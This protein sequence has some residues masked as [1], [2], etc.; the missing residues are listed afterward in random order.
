MALTTRLQTVPY[1]WTN[2]PQIDIPGVVR[3]G[4]VIVRDSTVDVDA[5]PSALATQKISVE[6]TPGILP[7]TIPGWFNAS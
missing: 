5:I 7:M 1:S 3:G 6:H 2:R 4:P